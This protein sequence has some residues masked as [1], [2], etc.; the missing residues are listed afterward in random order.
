MNTM[1]P[2]E[3]AGRIGEG[4]LSFPVTHFGEDLRWQPK[5]YQEHIAWLLSYQPTGLFA[6][7]GTG[8]FFSLA[9]GEFAAVTRAA[10]EQTNFVVEGESMKLTLSIGLAVFPDHAK[11]TVELIKLADQ[12]MYYGKRKSRNIVFLAG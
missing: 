7:G 3:M 2:R 11:S 8:E 4:L 9:P 10:V 6:T 5:L 12:A 1:D